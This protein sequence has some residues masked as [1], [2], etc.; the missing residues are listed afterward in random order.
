VSQELYYTS[1]PKGLIPGS[2][3]FC[4]V[5]TT[6][7]LSA[8]L[9]DK[10]ESLS[11]YRHLFPP[12]DTRASLNPVVFSH[13]RVS[14][15]GKVYNVVSRICAAGLDYSE[16]TN[17]FAH[18]VVLETSELPLGGPAWLLMQRGFMEEAWDGEVRVLPKGRAV[19]AGD[20][21]PRICQ[22]WQDLTGDAGW[23]GVLAESFSPV[24][25]RVV[26]LI[27][28]PGMDMLP[29]LAEAQALLPCERR[30]EIA[31]STYF[32]GLSQDISC[33]W[34][35]VS[36]GSAEAKMARR[37]PDAL[38]LNLSA[39]LGTPQGGA[40]IEYA[41][42]G[43]AP[44]P[45]IN[46][47]EQADDRPHTRAR[48]G[49]PEEKFYAENIASLSIPA[50]GL[51]RLEMKSSGE[52]MNSS[53]PGNA[54]I[55][56]RAELSAPPP[57]NR[58]RMAEIKQE[59]LRSRRWPVAFL[60]GV[61]A[62]II[63]TLLAI[64]SYFYL[65]GFVIVRQNRAAEVVATAS[66]NN[67]TSVPS[68]PSKIDD[69]P[70][71][72]PQPKADVVQKLQSL[73]SKSGF[74]KSPSEQAP[75]AQKAKHTPAT[76]KQPNNAV[77]SA[78]PGVTRF[79]PLPEVGFE[80][81]EKP[82][83]AHGL[84]GP[85]NQ[86]RMA[87]RG[88]KEFDL[89]GQRA[90]IS[91]KMAQTVLTCRCALPD[92]I[93]PEAQEVAN[94]RT[95]PR[96]VFFAWADKST[97]LVKTARNKIPGLIL[98]I[99]NSEKGKE[100]WA[101]RKEPITDELTEIRLSYERKAYIGPTLWTKYRPKPQGELLFDQAEIEMDGRN[102]SLKTLTHVDGSAIHIECD[103]IVLHSKATREEN[104]KGKYTEFMMKGARIEFDADKDKVV[105]QLVIEEDSRIIA[106]EAAALLA[107]AP[108]PPH[109]LRIK[110]LVI[111]TRV[112]GIRVPVAR[113]RTTQILRP[114]IQP[115]NVPVPAKAIQVPAKAVGN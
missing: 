86:I 57:L 16:R 10:L 49:H 26:Y 4:T 102:L 83:G 31:F 91:E 18:H 6:R 78:D 66:Q 30:W 51:E 67:P 35:C 36:N 107:N 82:I 37:L 48:I 52:V 69:D 75:P 90:R 60:I 40:L 84:Q 22:A 106:K 2:R 104:D 1:A 5:A 94:F 9:V 64:T 54:P 70:S 12:L 50:Q 33:I 11:A 14:V 53:L 41:R 109:V 23:A 15:A 113:F 63:L 25:D 62:G 108:I 7:G 98:E 24:S 44:P 105:L 76:G 114:N 99:A 56:H 71:A 72:K 73:K 38:I 77:V 81:R 42:T 27:F 80:V 45:S 93:D 32:T 97:D 13:I 100:Y 95:D 17:K 8:N 85:A 43:Q 79:V 29:L 92:S 59:P 87:L 111:S 34:R 74:A 20:S 58:K 39:P 101:L 88:E 65:G 68:Y 103:P 115:G 46:R 96:N 61:S 112:A 89:N 110:S 21:A 47:P 28:E 55:E 19:P 3:G